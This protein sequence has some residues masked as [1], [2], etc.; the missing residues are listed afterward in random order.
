[1][2]NRGLNAESSIGYYPYNTSSLPGVNSRLVEEVTVVPEQVSGPRQTRGEALTAQTGALRVAGA[3]FV[4]HAHA[5]S[6]AGCSPVYTAPP[7]PPLRLHDTISIAGWSYDHLPCGAGV[8]YGPCR[9]YPFE[10]KCPPQSL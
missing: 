4:E 5:S 8:R 9:G 3:Y 6:A 10:L 7:V 1:M 2:R